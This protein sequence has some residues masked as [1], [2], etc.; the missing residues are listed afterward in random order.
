MG[1]EVFEGGID[2]VGEEVARVDG[3]QDEG[4]DGVVEVVEV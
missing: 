2:G 3:V 4:Y 1:V